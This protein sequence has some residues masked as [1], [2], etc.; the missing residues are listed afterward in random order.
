MTAAR[1]ASLIAPQRP[2]SSN[3][4]PQPAHNPVVASSVQTL[5]QGVAMGMGAVTGKREFR[6]V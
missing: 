6:I 2:I 1:S 4:L 3:V 5:M